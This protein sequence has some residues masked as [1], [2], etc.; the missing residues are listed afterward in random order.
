MDQALLDH[1][2]SYLTD[3]RRDIFKKVLAERTRHFTVVT[4]D[5]YQ[6]HNTSAVMRSCEVFGIQD[7][8]VVEESLGMNLDR[9]IAI[10]AQ[11][12]VDIQR[13]DT[14]SKCV[15]QLR[16]KGYQIIATTPHDDAQSLEDFDVSKKTALFF[17]READGASDEVMQCADGY[18]KIPMFGFTESLNVSVSAAI[19]LQNIVSRMRNENVN[20]ELNKEECVELEFKWAKKTIKRVD[21]IIARFQEQ[22]N[23]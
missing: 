8:H 1:L 17:G 9:E 2:L 15:E 20:W 13:H 3:R 19:I 6:L 4:E 5:I 16:S 21:E 10:G 11:K 12:W 7:M 22:K 18:L 23:L 14:V